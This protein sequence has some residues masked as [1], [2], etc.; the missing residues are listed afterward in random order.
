M[1]PR[2]KQASGTIL[3]KLSELGIQQDADADDAA[4]GQIAEPQLN[5]EDIEDDESD[6]PLD[7]A[8]GRIDDDD[9]EEFGIGGDSPE[10]TT[11]RSKLRDQ[12]FAESERKPV[13]RPRKN[14]PP[15]APAPAPIG[16]QQ[17]EPQYAPLEPVVIPQPR[18]A[19]KVNRGA[20]PQPVASRGM[21]RLASKMPGAEQI[22]VYKRNDRQQLVVIGR[23][24][25]KDL[26][27]FANVEMFVFDMIKP[28][29]GAGEYQIMGLDAMG[30][31]IP[32][33]SCIIEDPPQHTQEN[34]MVDLVKTLL[35]QKEASN[36]TQAPIPPVNP[37]NM[38]K[39][40]HE[41]QKS[42]AQPAPVAPPRDDS[43]MAAVIAASGQQMQAM[44]QM[45]QAQNSQTTQLLIAA[46]QPKEDPMMKMLLAKLV[47]EK[48]SSGLGNLPLPPP[49]PPVDSMAGI[50]DILTLFMPLIAAYLK[51]D[52]GDDTK[53]LLKTLI[54]QKESETLKPKEVIE[55]MTSMQQNN[56]GSDDFRKSVENLQMMT[57]ISKALNSGN[58]G[59]SSATFWDAASALF[60]N[61]DFAG[62]IAQA[63]RAKAETAQKKEVINA[64]THLLEKKGQLL[65]KMRNRPSQPPVAQIRPAAPAQ[66]PV[67]TQQSQQHPNVVHMNPRTV[68]MQPP[69]QQ[70]QVIPPGV[71]IPP[72]PAGTGE[73]VKGLM[74]A[75]DDGELMGKTVQM[76]IY[77]AE[78]PEWAPMAE[79]LLSTIGAGEKDK[80]INIVRNVF[81]GFASMRIMP[82]EL[83]VRVCQSFINNFEVIRS[84][85]LEMNLVSP[86]ESEDPFEAALEETDEEEGEE[87]ESDD[88]EG[89]EE[90]YEDE[91]DASSEEKE[92]VAG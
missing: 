32:A 71:K 7:A 80:A 70:Q 24:S 62:S 40:V 84:Q 74:E 59:S 65:E 4:V 44:M 66:G 52:G 51:K 81:T 50:K 47:E 92:P 64:E 41:L 46:M 15:Q 49:P 54:A 88:E 55:L 60:S 56:K 26:T 39:D 5:P 79:M 69:Q 90:E 34:N 87:E 53:D 23:Y 36:V 30:R 12:L 45:M 58:E 6:D 76:L 91:E 31:E 13:G 9:N 73:H 86:E 21:G 75:K 11:P 89:D 20:A 25:P 82:Q 57:Q 17:T 28:K 33:G 16:Y 83:A 72:L 8:A 48:S 43:T 1:P 38:L 29:F 78:F 14:P 2:I 63:V 77:F 85:V 22:V 18:V 27:G 35:A 68:T 37:I 67:P 3:D 10:P 42:M 61:R 19:G